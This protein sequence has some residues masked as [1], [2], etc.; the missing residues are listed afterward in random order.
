MVPTPFRK[1]TPEPAWASLRVRQQA[2]QLWFSQVNRLINE[3]PALDSTG[4]SA[5]GQLVR[6]QVQPVATML[7][8]LAAAG[9]DFSVP[10]ADVTD[11]LN[12]PEFT[13]YPALA[14]AVLQFLGGKR[15]RRP[16]FLDVLVFN[17]E[18]SAGNP[19]PRKVEDVNSFVLEAAVLKASNERHGETVSN[20]RDLLVD[21]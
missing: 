12:N 2:E 6:L 16:V 19:S 17:Y 9:I 15:L 20:F 8:A 14:E 3:T 5:L 4:R 10:E 11:W 1:P 21:M 7:G 18:H 13:P